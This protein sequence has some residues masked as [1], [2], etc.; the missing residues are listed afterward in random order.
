MVGLE[1]RLVTRFQWGQVTQIEKPDVE[2]RLAILRKK[3][4]QMN[5]RVAD[6]ILMYLAEHIR[7]DV[8]HLEGALTRVTAYASLM[9]HPVTIQVVEQLL[10]DLLD[11]ERINALTIETIQ[12][13]VAEYYDIRLAD[14]TSKQRPQAI[15]F[16]R[17]VAMYLCRDLTD[18]SSPTI[19]EA[20]SR[21]HAT[22]LHACTLIN[23][24]VTSDPDLRQTIAMLRHKL[25]R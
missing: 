15:A 7:S 4:E 16:P 21:N 6:E 5:I 18:F 19:G 23:Q 20:F 9:G 12:R 24:R 17:Q 1:Q 22:V 8:R 10:R 13:I 25:G 11:Q 14:M 2:T 3:Q